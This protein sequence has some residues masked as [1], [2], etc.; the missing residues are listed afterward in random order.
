MI[1][2]LEDAIREIVNKGVLE[3]TKKI[4]NIQLL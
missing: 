2:Q 4:N 1:D 3:R